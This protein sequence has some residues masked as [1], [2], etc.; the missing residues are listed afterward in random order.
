MKPTSLLVA[1]TLSATLFALACDDKKDTGVA[2]DGSTKKADAKKDDAKKDDAKKDDA[3]KD[4]AK[5]DDGDIVATCQKMCDKSVTCAEE[6][7]K[8]AGAPEEVLKDAKAE[9]EKGLEECKKGCSD[10]AESATAEDKAQVAKVEACIKK[11]CAEYV[12]CMDALE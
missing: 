12:T 2:A 4:D 3:K 9:A 8:S 10:D 5:K 11:D 1:V 6:V 7:A